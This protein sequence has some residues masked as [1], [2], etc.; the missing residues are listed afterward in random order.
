ME[1]FRLDPNGGP[2][3]PLRGCPVEVCTVGV[4]QIKTWIRCPRAWFN[5]SI[6]RLPTKDKPH[7][8]IGTAVHAL[9]EAY[10]LGTAPKFEPD[11]SVEIIGK[12]RRIHAR[13]VHLLPPPRSP[14]V[15]GVEHTVYH[16]L[17]LEGPFAGY[18][19]L[20]RGTVD[21]W[22]WH[23]MGDGQGILL[24]DHKTAG[25]TKFLDTPEKLAADVQ[26]LCY[27]WALNAEAAKS[28]QGPFPIRMRK[29]Y[30]PTAEPPKFQPFPVEVDADP[31]VVSAMG[32]WISKIATLM[33]SDALKSETEVRQNFDACGDFGGC[34][35][36]NRCHPPE[37]IFDRVFQIEE[38]RKG[39]T[40]VTAEQ[41]QEFVTA[42]TGGGAAAP[43]PFDS[44]GE[45]QIRLIYAMTLDAQGAPGL[46]R[47][48]MLPRVKAHFGAASPASVDQWISY[49]RKNAPEVNPP[50]HVHAGPPSAAP[51]TPPAPA[52]EK[53]SG[54]APSD[55]ASS[56]E[57]TEI[58]KVFRDKL[59]PKPFRAFIVAD[60]TP[61]KTEAYSTMREAISKGEKPA[62]NIMVNTTARECLARG[63]TSAQVAEWV[64][65]AGAP[66]SP[67]VETRVPV[68]AS[69]L[70]APVAN[71]ARAE[72]I[73][74]YGEQI[75]P[76]VKGL[77]A[78]LPVRLQWAILR[79]IGKTDAEIRVPGTAS[80]T[81]AAQRLGELFRL[82]FDSLSS[83]AAWAAGQPSGWVAAEGEPIRRFLESVDKATFA[84]LADW[85]AVSD[86]F[87]KAVADPTSIHGPR[88]ALAHELCVELQERALITFAEFR[89]WVHSVTGVD[90]ATYAPA[91]V[92][93]AVPPAPPALPPAPPAAPAPVS[94]APPSTP[95]P[96]PAAPVSVAPPLDP[97]RAFGIDTLTAG[98]LGILADHLRA[99][100]SEIDKL[101]T[102]A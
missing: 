101:R 72:G 97:F 92:A 46:T 7:F 82:G 60:K 18:L 78:S 25:S 16:W 20:Y 36:Q 57:E 11:T 44:L 81:W 83:W 23:P 3:I 96:A 41:R 42:A 77:I 32:E 39:K 5:E 2:P 55:V 67:P 26:T 10:I 61:A 91:P 76:A 99:A 100:A 4:S 29:N 52:P 43:S 49:A 75:D 54:R 73:T 27:S 94:V 37:S 31:G 63:I 12:A 33:A 98:A 48:D 93:P 95:P 47:A 58:R 15:G 64:A 19:A 86:R 45:A 62:S 88:E 79:K 69:D 24:T 65:T 53:A 59:A 8:R 17:I 34:D 50:E 90:P 51:S 87:R 80:D 30:F 102:G 66:V 9:N 85:A 28:G 35:W 22:E 6:S 38:S 1:I 89:A 68:K 13:G 84:R 21:L 56:P 71:A 14:S 40:T 74:P 70:P